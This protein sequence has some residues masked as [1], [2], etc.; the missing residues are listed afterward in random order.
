MDGGYL[1]LWSGDRIPLDLDAQWVDAEI[2]GPEAEA[3]A[4]AF[5][6]E[7]A[8]ALYD[9]PRHAQDKP[10]GLFATRAGGYAASLRTLAPRV[11]PGERPRRAIAAGEPGFA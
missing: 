3:A 1:G 9:I 11:P 4:E 2:V 5:H 10:A 6:R 7:T 8:T